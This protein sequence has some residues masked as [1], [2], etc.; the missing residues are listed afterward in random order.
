M[1]CRIGEIEVWRILELNGPI[2]A[3]DYLYPTAGPDVVQQITERDPGAICPQ[4]GGLILPV[5]GFLLRTPD[6]LILVDACIGNHKTARLEAWHMRDSDRFLHA[7]AAA[8]AAPEDVTHVMCTHLHIDHVGWNTRRVDGRWVPTFPN[9]RYLFP[10]ADV[11]EMAPHMPETF[12]ESV[13]P[14]IEAGLAEEVTP[15]FQIGDL[16]RLMPTP[17]HTPG[18]VSVLLESQGQRAVITGD[19]LHSIAQCW[20]PDWHF[21]FDFD[22]DAAVTSRQALLGHA[23][24]TGQ[25][26]LGTHFTLPSLGRIRAEGDVFAWEPD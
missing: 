18:H 6:H 19:A 4:T 14:V 23:A 15:G 12:A 9:A 5:Q 1:L 11:T 20:H 25:R 8:G 22:A 26:V 13:T 7:L 10:S 3:P 21:V 2:D 17:G 16:V 24:E